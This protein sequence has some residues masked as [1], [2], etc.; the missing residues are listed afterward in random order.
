[1]KFVSHLDMNR[2]MSRLVSRAGIPVWYTEGF[3]RHFYM[4]F[5]VPLSLGFE[6]L[7]E[8]MDFKLTDDDYSLSECLERMNKV[9]PPDIEFFKIGEPKE[10]MK[11]IAFAEYRLRF[12]ALSDE[13]A[14]RLT[15]FLSQKSVICEKTGKKGRVKEIDI[16]PKIKSFSFDGNELTLIL[17]AG[18]ED[19]LNPNLVL[20]AFYAQTAAP[21]VFCTVTRTMLFNK[22]L[23]PFE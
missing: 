18:N 11:E 16:I 2:F 10:S 21:P 14:E 5:A 1:M 23:K 12:E 13:F 9:C 15:G 20:T 7:Y 8:V 19:T 17:N 3:N 22:K 6:G 4:N